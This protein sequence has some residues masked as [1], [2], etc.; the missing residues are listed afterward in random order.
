MDK[1]A[2]RVVGQAETSLAA[3]AR[4][5]PMKKGARRVLK[6]ALASPYVVKWPACCKPDLAAGVLV[7]WQS[8]IRSTAG[9]ESSDAPAPCMSGRLTRL[10]MCKPWVL[11]GLNDVSRAL[12]RHAEPHAAVDV[13]VLTSRIKPQSL[14]EHVLVLCEARRVPLLLLDMSS[15]ELG[16]ALGLRKALAVAV[17]AAT[18]P[19]VPSIGEMEQGEATARPDALDELVAILR[20]CAHTP[21]GAGALARASEAPLSFMP[22]ELHAVT[23]R[24]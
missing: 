15:D 11:I 18:R 9:C 14:V 21:D 10:C 23:A 16:A 12:E 2:A 13:V 8:W 4:A 7:R 3:T 5:K 20:E 24:S 6:L 17:R 19:T 1:P 22:F